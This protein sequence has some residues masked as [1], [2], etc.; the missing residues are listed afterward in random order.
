MTTQAWE[1]IGPTS[2]AL[3]QLSKNG[4]TIN[5]NEVH[6]WWIHQS[7]KGDISLLSS[8]EVSR[9]QSFKRDAVRNRFLSY[10]SALRII[11]SS[12]L[13]VQPDKI[14]FQF[15]EF[16]K[17]SLLSQRLKFNLSHSEDWAVCAVSTGQELGIDCEYNRNLNDLMTVAHEVFSSDELDKLR[18]FDRSKQHHYFYN[19]WT[20]KEAILKGM[21]TGLSYAAKAISVNQ[22]HL[23]SDISL[24]VPGHGRWWI[25][26]LSSPKCFYS[27]IA[28]PM[29]PTDVSVFEFRN[30]A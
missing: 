29:K 21:G 6:I 27:A 8:D 5:A 3:K 9:Y 2:D 1:A 14:R 12:Y 24:S 15:N 13:S 16:G 18:Q 28:T 4:L 10:H 20:I 23:Q 19:L 26:Q 22:Q 30:R 25:T 11:L 7:V 17:P